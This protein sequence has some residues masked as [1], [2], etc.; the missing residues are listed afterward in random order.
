M[1]RGPQE[2]RPILSLEPKWLEP[3]WPE[4]FKDSLFEG[5]GLADSR[6]RVLPVAGKKEAE[7]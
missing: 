7:K 6:D 1:R 3:K 2:V 4:L 5:F